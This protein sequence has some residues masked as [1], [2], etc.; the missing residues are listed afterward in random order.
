MVV[1]SFNPCEKYARQNGVPLPQMGMKIK[2]DIIFFKKKHLL[3]FIY[4][5]YIFF[6]MI[7]EKYYIHII[8]ETTYKKEMFEETDVR[9]S[10]PEAPYNT[11]Q[12]WPLG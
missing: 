1:S 4:I 9:V 10:G 7:L 8:F 5:L 12:V 3:F 6:N 2:K 11:P